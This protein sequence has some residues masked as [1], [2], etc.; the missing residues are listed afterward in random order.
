MVI[1]N[2]WATSKLLK[3]QLK[4]ALPLLGSTF[5]TLLVIA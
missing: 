2:F 5:E 4:H 3:T 1:I